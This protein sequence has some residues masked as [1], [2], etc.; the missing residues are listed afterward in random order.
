[1]TKICADYMQAEELRKHGFCEDTAD[2]FCTEDGGASN[3]P[4]CSADGEKHYKRTW[5]L[6]ALLN[7]LPVFIEDKR[8]RCTYLLSLTKNEIKYVRD[9][10]LDIAKISARGDLVDAAV[11]ILCRLSEWA[12]KDNR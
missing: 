12:E 10:D 8:E 1:M 5:S 9:T 6:G 7:M 2:M 4:I 3:F 11:H